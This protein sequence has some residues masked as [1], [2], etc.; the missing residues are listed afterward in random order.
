MLIYEVEVEELRTRSLANRSPF[1][2]VPTS[3]IYYPTV[4]GHEGLENLHLITMQLHNKDCEEL[5]TNFS[6]FFFLF[7]L[8]VQCEYDAADL[9][10]AAD[11]RSLYAVTK[12]PPVAAVGTIRVQMRIATGHKHFNCCTVVNQTSVKCQQ[13]L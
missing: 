6:F 9:K 2:S 10:R 5:K 7:S 4:C 3:S 1:R 13:P 12:P 8:Q 11:L